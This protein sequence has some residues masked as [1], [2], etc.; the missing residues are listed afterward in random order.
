MHPYSP[1]KVFH[2]RRS[3]DILKE[4][5]Q[6]NPT[7]VQIILSDLCNQSCHFCA[8]RM[9]GY[10]SNQLFGVMGDDGKVNNNPNR[11]LPYAKVSEILNDCK[12]MGVK[13][14][15]FTGGGE[16]TVHPF[17]LE[18]LNTAVNMGFDVGLVTNG[19]VQKHGIIET[20]GRLSWVRFSVD[21]GTKDT[22]AALRKTNVH[23]F[24]K[25]WTHIRDTCEYA[26]LGGTKTLVGVGFV[27]TAENW[28]EVARAA[29]LAKDAGANNFR[30]S[31]VFQPD[32]E[33][34]FGGF[35]KECAALCREA[36]ALETPDFKVFNMFGDRMDDMKQAH[37]DYSFCGYQ[38]FTTYIGADHNVYRCCITAYNDLGLVGS[39]KEQSFRQLWE[40]ESKKKNFDSFDSTACPRCQFNGKN[41]T[42][43]YALTN[44]PTHVNFV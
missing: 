2:H 30:I 20:L 15:Q 24:A 7:H 5:G 43:A 38:H 32:D 6:P 8:Y 29:A 9:E 10:T 21:A 19:L 26:R 31:A 36:Q 11:M 12:E 33:K 34:Y 22:Y 23:N 41:R 25:V 42:I 27:V 14:L 1:L 4:G 16:P 3:L 39:I 13:A 17:H 35:H 40:S 37:P 44:N 18:I 28:R